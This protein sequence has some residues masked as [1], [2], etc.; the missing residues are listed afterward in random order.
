VIQEVDE[1]PGPAL[2]QFRDHDHSVVAAVRKP[3]RRS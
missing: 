1:Q 3:S 2:V